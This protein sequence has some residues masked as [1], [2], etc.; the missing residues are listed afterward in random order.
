[1]SETHRTMMEKVFEQINGLNVLSDIN[2][3][4]LIFNDCKGFCRHRRSQSQYYC[5]CLRIYSIE[6]ESLVVQDCD[7]YK[8]INSYEYCD[9]YQ[10]S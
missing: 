4:H 10:A 5:G 9:Y 7:G 2:D 8:P 1:M 3:R 6:G